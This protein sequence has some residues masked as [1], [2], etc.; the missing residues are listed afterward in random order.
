MRRGAASASAPRRRPPERDVG[1][2]PDDDCFPHV[3]AGGSRYGA[4][5]C[6]RMT[7]ARRSSA[8]PVGG[9]RL[10]A[11]DRQN[12]TSPAMQTIVAIQKFSRSPRIWCE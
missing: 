7:S 5:G 3:G 2:A 12:Q 4:V 1:R 10:A 8:R 9:G 6:L 11:L